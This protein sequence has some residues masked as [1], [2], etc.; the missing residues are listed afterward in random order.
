MDR[1]RVAGFTVAEFNNGMR[2]GKGTS[3]KFECEVCGRTWAFPTDGDF[4]GRPGNRLLLLNHK[5][6]HEE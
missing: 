3:W 4:E 5:R 1:P 2:H 6:S